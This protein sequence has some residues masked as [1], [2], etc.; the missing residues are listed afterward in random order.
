M[1]RRAVPLSLWLAAAAGACTP[2]GLWVYDD[3]AFDATRPRLDRGRATDSTVV[4]ALDVWN[5]NDY[6]VTT[7]RLELRLRL[8]GD[9]VGHFQRDSAIPLPRT[10]AATVRLPFT[11]S[12]DATRKLAAIPAGTDHF[13]V[14]G[15]AVFQTPFGERRVD[16]THRVP[17]SPLEPAATE[18]TKPPLT[19]VR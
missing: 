7:S 3:P 12:A 1:I 18:G 11:P 13:Q 8:D 9:V 4:V 2:A 16:V 17:A 6:E 15:L 10:R 14:E 5:P 19:V